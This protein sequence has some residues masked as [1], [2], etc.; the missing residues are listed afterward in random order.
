[1]LYKR[2]IIALTSLLDLLFI[3]IFAYQM[4][5][6]TNADEYVQA[7]VQKR[8]SL[9]IP[10]QEIP[11]QSELVAELQDE[12]KRVKDKLNAIKDKA[13]ELLTDNMQAQEYYE[14][15]E[16]LRDELNK[17]ER[18]LVAVKQE[19]E[20]IKN[21]SMREGVI[22]ITTKDA[23]MTRM[24]VGTWVNN[25]KDKSLA[26]AINTTYSDNGRFTNSGTMVATRNVT[27][28]PS[29]TYLMIGDSM[30]FKTSGSWW[31]KNGYIFMIV[32]SSNNTLAYPIGY[33]TQKNI[34]FAGNKVQLRRDKDNIS[35]EIVR[36]R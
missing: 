16:R 34:T 26:Y 29:E 28:Y 1:M 10:D 19:N 22:P 15:A 13:R 14:Q 35:Y 24:L 7:E 6:K 21:Q 27:V 5:I 11:D 8:I 23:E 33:C 25:H 31:I 4:D 17:K 3:L 2:P 12:N 20:R 36:V 30:S 9:D 18:K 32:E